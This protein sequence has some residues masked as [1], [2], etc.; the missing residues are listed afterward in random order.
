MAGVCLPPIVT[1]VVRLLQLS[2]ESHDV[3]AQLVTAAWLK[4]RQKSVALCGGR[5]QLSGTL[6][7]NNLCFK[8]ELHDICF[9]LAS[10]VSVKQCGRHSAVL[11]LKVSSAFLFSVS[12]Y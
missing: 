12:D 6:Y 3:M 2:Y 10:E 1:G 4:I 8:V 11:S 5:V 7:S 9:F